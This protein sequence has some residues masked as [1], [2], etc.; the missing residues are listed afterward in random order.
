MHRQPQDLWLGLPPTRFAA[1]DELFRRQLADLADLSAADN[2]TALAARVA[3]VERRPTAWSLR[4]LA[5][6]LAARESATGTA[7]PVNHLALG[8]LTLAAA[9]GEE[10]AARVLM[11]AHLRLIRGWRVVRGG[12]CDPSLLWVVERC[13]RGTEVEQQVRDFALR[14][15]KTPP[16]H[17]AI[18]GLI[19]TLDPNRVSSR[20]LDIDP[21]PGD[22]AAPSANAPDVPGEGARAGDARLRAA[23]RRYMPWLAP[24]ISAICGDGV[25]DDA[26]LLI[27][28]PSG[29]G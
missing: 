25:R 23:L 3:A 2:D 1:D 7:P 29:N 11:V 16:S 8:W 17:S 22:A 28:G 15:L 5:E 6:A 14:A 12:G 27:C 26:P 21:C 24:A 9:R 10:T 13:A 20:Y 19:G 4:G 18:T